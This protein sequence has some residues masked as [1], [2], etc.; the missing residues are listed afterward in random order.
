MNRWMSKQLLAFT[1]GRDA[2]V[3]MAIVALILVQGG[4][5]SKANPAA[6][7][8]PAS[9]SSTPA[10]TPVATQT[11]GAKL[12]RTISTP[13]PIS[14]I[15]ISPDGKRL[16]AIVQ[17][18]ALRAWDLESGSEIP[19]DQVQMLPNLNIELSKVG[20]TKDGKFLN[21][22]ARPDDGLFLS[23]SVIPQDSC[24]LSADSQWVL[25]IHHDG[26]AVDLHHVPSGRRVRGYIET[27]SPVMQICFS[28]NGDHYFAALASG[29]IVVRDLRTGLEV[30][31]IPDEGAN[32]A[33]LLSSSD[34]A[35][36]AFSDGRCKLLDLRKSGITDLQIKRTVGPSNPVV[37]TVSC[38]NAKSFLAVTS[39]G[40]RVVVDA[41]TGDELMVL[42]RSDFG[43]SIGPA[44]TANVP[45][46]GAF[47]PDCRRLVIPVGSGSLQVW[48]LPN[49]PAFQRPSNP[50]SGPTVDLA[51][52]TQVRGPESNPATATP[53]RK[54]RRAEPEI[55]NSMSA[56]AIGRS[57]RRGW[58]TGLSFEDLGS[59]NLHQ[60][61]LATGTMEY[62]IPIVRG[63]DVYDKLIVS[64]DESRIATA[65]LNGAVVVVDPVTK[66]ILS[67][68]TPSAELATPVHCLSF[69]RDRSLL[70]VVRS[71]TVSVHRTDA[72]DS[73]RQFS[74]PQ[75][76]S[77]NSRLG[78]AGPP[79][80]GPP[81]AARPL[82]AGPGPV[83]GG[84]GSPAAS[85]SSFFAAT[86][87]PDSEQL[88]AVTA[89]GAL[90]NF[91]MDTGKK[92][93]EFQCQVPSAVAFNAD[94][95]QV[96]IGN[97]ELRSEANN[98]QVVSAVIYD[99]ATGSQ[100]VQLKD[101]DPD[102]MRCGEFSDDGRWLVTVH[103]SG[104]CQR[105]A[106][107]TGHKSGFSSVSDVEGDGISMGFAPRGATGPSVLPSP[108]PGPRPGVPMGVTPGGSA[109]AERSM[110]NLALLNDATQFWT[111]NR[112]GVMELWNI[113]GDATPASAPPIEKG[114]TAIS[115]RGTLPL[116]AGI[117]DVAMS[118]DATRSIGL[119]Q[120]GDLVIW[121]MGTLDVEKSLKV[122]RQS[123]SSQLVFQPDS[124]GIAFAAGASPRYLNLINFNL[125]PANDG[126][127][128]AFPA[129]GTGT[130]KAKKKAAGDVLSPGGIFGDGTYV[131]PGSSILSLAYCSDAR[132]L[133]CG[134][135]DGAVSRLD[136]TNGQSKPL[137]RRSYPVLKVGASKTTPRMMAYDGESIAVWD[138]V[139]KPAREIKV[140]LQSPG[141][142]EFTF[143]GTSALIW[144]QS[145][146]EVVVFNLDQGSETKR[147]AFS[148]G[149][150]G[151]LPFA[152]SADG[153][154]LLAASP[155]TLVT[156]APPD[157]SL[158]GNVPSG[159][160]PGPGVAGAAGAPGA[161]GGLG[162]PVG[163]GGLGFQ[164][165]SGSTRGRTL[166]MGQPTKPRGGVTG[167]DLIVDH[168][169]PSA[170]STDVRLWSLETGKTVAVL[171]GHTE[172]VIALALSA[173]GKSA[174]T[175][176]LDRA[177]RVWSLPSP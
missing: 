177:V 116:S 142:V 138:S 165:R 113:R 6:P 115:S 127:T 171:R 111:V 159:D 66:K 114:V 154:W 61:D 90:V 31:R 135:A 118:P 84:P 44:P 96:A 47:S 98:Q 97:A 76:S 54:T 63:S 38:P 48:E 174:V 46:I 130:G 132:Y 121:K 101:S 12:L 155:T 71:S 161:P 25:A 158:L 160:F 80:F 56:V 45:L 10:Q 147:L 149:E 129:K 4:C 27:Q 176:G 131:D 100:L 11:D 50:S 19:V 141:R 167:A 35:L 175:A 2:V 18:A 32:C 83:P 108:T 169:D 36:I 145:Q 99:V 172:A 24:T 107:Q 124:K 78:L 57:G 157:Q 40:D 139:T 60:F 59:T 23:A 29:E 74:S 120:S 93:S 109:G 85:A 49:V 164:G 106:T 33:E 128:T 34:Q 28:R 150:I 62:S 88:V 144:D 5:G 79:P 68:I 163:P 30:R 37:R 162:A 103:A 87:S 102:L 77:T 153:K 26:R 70:V 20:F 21:I 17:Q 151:Q 9:T 136:R 117:F 137:D 168:I 170:G 105:W 95:T 126:T 119:A 7:V 73:V 133:I 14:R 51:F 52:G 1:R 42:E 39:N 8:T 123:V 58:G 92:L 13:R 81:G 134:H 72:G 148:K 64:A 112:N 143:D 146:R 41:S 67:R 122:V 86:L 89:E 104:R 65:A 16:L 166:P 94:A 53:F 22:P 125:T 43:S 15:A 173:D 75:T 140:P 91:E 82:G 110:V 69:S 156:V 152:I 3:V 55:P